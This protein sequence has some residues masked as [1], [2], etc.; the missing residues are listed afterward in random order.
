VRILIASASATLHAYLLPYLK[1]HFR[2]TLGPIR[3]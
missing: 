3:R 1:I 2:S